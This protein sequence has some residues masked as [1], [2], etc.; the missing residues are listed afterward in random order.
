MQCCCDFTNYLDYSGNFL[1]VCYLIYFELY[2][3]Y[4]TYV[5]SYVTG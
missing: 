1:S 4:I 2:C 3:Y 5:I